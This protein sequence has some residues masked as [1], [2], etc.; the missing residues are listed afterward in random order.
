[1]N[2]L[3]RRQHR[4]GLFVQFQKFDDLRDVLRENEFVA[5]RQDRD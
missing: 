3:G 4:S 1:L 2:E 5:A